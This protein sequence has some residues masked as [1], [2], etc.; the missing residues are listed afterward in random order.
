[1]FT[2]GSVETIRLHVPATY[3]ARRQQVRD[4]IIAQ[5]AQILLQGVV[6]YIL[7]VI[8]SIDPHNGMNFHGGEY[9][10]AVTVVILLRVCFLFLSIYLPL[11]L[12]VSLYDFF[13]FTMCFLFLPSIHLSLYACVVV[14]LCLSVCISF[15]T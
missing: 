13:I 8:W 9:F 7:S 10:S 2:G 1:M 15:S 4:A 11:V 3:L 6:F 12:Y 14:S 5:R